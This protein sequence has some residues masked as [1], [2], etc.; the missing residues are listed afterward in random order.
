M[1]YCYIVFK[2]G[3]DGDTDIDGVYSTV[4]LATAQCEAMVKDA[5]SNYG[6]KWV[7]RDGEHSARWEKKGN[8]IAWERHEIK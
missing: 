8:W 2:E 4:E 7:K 5:E 6:G 3:Y 1:K